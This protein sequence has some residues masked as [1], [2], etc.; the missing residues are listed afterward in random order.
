[1]SAQDNTPNT[2]S[3]TTSDWMLK[4][5]LEDRIVTLSL[6]R[7]QLEKYQEAF[8]TFGQREK[9]E[10]LTEQER[11]FRETE[12]APAWETTYNNML[13]ALSPTA[14]NPFSMQEEMKI[15][16]EE[17]FHTNARLQAH[18]DQFPQQQQEQEQQPTSPQEKSFDE[19]LAEATARYNATHAHKKSRTR[20]QDH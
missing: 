7:H 5:W 11:Q 6:Y 13:T 18:E 4:A 8:D 19:Q 14:S 20:G 12:L 10:T 2:G 16:C 1:M 17:L 15:Y 9:A 3:S